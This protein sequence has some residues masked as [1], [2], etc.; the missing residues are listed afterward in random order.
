MKK[1]GS[2]LLV[3][4]LLS[5][6]WVHAQ[7]V[8]LDKLLEEETKKS[9]TKEP[10]SIIATFK[11]TRISNGHSVEVLPAGVLDVKI[12]HRFGTINSG[13]KE[14]F[15]LDQAVIRL[16]L[17]YGINDKLMVGIGRTSYQKQVDG[18][19][20]YKM[21]QQKAQG[22]PVTVT[23]VAS[24]MYRTDDYDAGLPY[25]PNNTD[26]LSYAFQLLVAR[27]FTEGISLQF[28]PTVVHYNIVPVSTDPNDI[29]SLGMGGRFKLTP[30][31]SFNIEY[32]YNLPG[33]K[34][35]GT[36]NSLAMGFDI[37]TGGHVFQ[38]VF[39]NGQGIAEKPFIT[40][41]TGDFFKG[42]IHFGFNI[43]RVFQ[44]GGKKKQKEKNG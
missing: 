7:D 24:M 12:Q 37:E 40:E 34:F 15:G 1:F 19:L 33:H 30:S 23:G 20:K 16:G 39:T 13:M 6:V 28:M 4:L 25:V 9:Q 31:T 3:Y 21:L 26:R 10:E 14:F 27:K 41:T 17:D 38:L 44:L 11:T 5:Q 29:I 32:Y 8:D 42:D 2:I 35:E 43:S 18:F 22:M 36:K